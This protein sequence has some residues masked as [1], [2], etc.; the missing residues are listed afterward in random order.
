M[1]TET[2][3]NK[4]T[5]LAKCAFWHAMLWGTILLVNLINFFVGQTVITAE[6]YATLIPIR[7]TIRFTCIVILLIILI[8]FI[9][10]SSNPEKE[11]ELAKLNKYKASHIS[12]YIFIVAI[13]ATIYIIKNFEFAFVGDFMDNTNLGLIIWAFSQILYNI[14]F[15]FVERD[16]LE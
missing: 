3:I 15:I 1:T 16:N 6:N 5:S 2:T 13:I 11:D 12:F 14:V 10:R 8:L 9:K 4:K 7:H